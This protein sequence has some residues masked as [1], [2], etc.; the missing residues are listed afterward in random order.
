MY[1]QQLKYVKEQENKGSAFVLRLSYKLP[2]KSY[3]P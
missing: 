2:S 1:N 3:N